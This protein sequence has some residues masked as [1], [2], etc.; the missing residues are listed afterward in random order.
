VKPDQKSR[1]KTGTERP[2]S[3]AEIL[4]APLLPARPPR[5]VPRGYDPE[6]AAAL[7]PLELENDVTGYRARLRLSASRWLDQIIARAITRAERRTR[8][9]PWHVGR[10]VEWVMSERRQIAY[11]VV[12]A[13]TAHQAG[14]ALSRRLAELAAKRFPRDGV[15]LDPDDMKRRPRLEGTN[16]RALEENPRAIERNPRARGTSPRQRRA[17]KQA[18]TPEQLPPEIAGDAA[19]IAALQGA[20]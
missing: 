18:S 17:S 12:R 15:I 4:A 19:A 3:L 5:N 11:D 6:I 9:V 8:R 1:P 7:V 16:P 10:G 13:L 20:G 14:D 2:T